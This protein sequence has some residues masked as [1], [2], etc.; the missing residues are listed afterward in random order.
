M[1]LHKK[2]WLG[3]AALLGLGATGFGLAGAGPLGGLLGTSAGA[4]GGAAGGFG[5]VGTGA[6]LAGGLG[7]GAADEAVGSL[8]GGTV[9]NPLS[10]SAGNLLSKVGGTSGV[11]NALK[12]GKAA[13]G[14]LGGS[15]APPPMPAMP[16][17]A[18]QPSPAPSMAYAP[19][20]VPTVA[21]GAMG[22]G[23]IDP[24]MLKKLLA[25]LQGSNYG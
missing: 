13:Q 16:R 11:S 24:D 21:P 25:Q 2:D 20:T 9:G 14:L 3:L 1:S 10:I 6:E 8:A 4:V 18:A 15:G 17:A 7:A 23:Q 12:M 5:A 22:A 19:P